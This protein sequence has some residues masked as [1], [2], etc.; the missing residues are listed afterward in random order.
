MAIFRIQ[1]RRSIKGFVLVFVVYR[2]FVRDFKRSVPYFVFVFVRPSPSVLYRLGFSVV[3][4]RSVEREK[5]RVTHTLFVLVV[6]LVF[7]RT[8]SSGDM[9][10]MPLV[11]ARVRAGQRMR[12]LPAN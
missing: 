9:Q 6:P 7:G 5:R 1:R 3:L 2:F 4:V 10:N 12:D 11:R 8:F